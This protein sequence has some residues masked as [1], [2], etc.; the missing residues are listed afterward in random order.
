[1][2]TLSKK[3]LTV[4]VS[5]ALLGIGTPAPAPGAGKSR[6]S[7][8]DPKYYELYVRQ[9]PQTL[10]LPPGDL[11]F[12]TALSLG[13]DKS[14][15]YGLPSLPPT[16]LEVKPLEILIFDPETAGATLQLAKLAY[17]EAAPAHFFDLKTTGVDPGSFEK[18]YHVKYDEPVLINLWCVESNI[19]LR[20][21][22]AAGKPG[23]YRAVPE[24][25]LEP[26]IYAINFS[27]AKGPRIY[28]GAL[29]FYPFV[30]GAAPAPAP[31]PVFNPAPQSKRP[32]GLPR[33]VVASPLPQGDSGQG[34]VV[35]VPRD[36]KE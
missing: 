9:G 18:V 22:A 20:L 21:T 28:T 31:P 15:F 24:Q 3:I 16:R 33:M 11:V 30:L 23:W 7:P 12:K 13:P 25:Q 36:L 26:G 14:G 5:L 19:P 6:Q 1:M 4:M 32:R 35:E 29:Y 27:G 8:Q 10:R 17:M 2:K 34:N